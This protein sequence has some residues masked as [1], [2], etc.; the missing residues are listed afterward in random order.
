MMSEMGTFRVNIEIENVFRPGT[1]IPVSGVLVDTGAELS[2]FP[3]TVLESIGVQRHERRRFRL[4]SGEV[5]E[6]WVG[7]VFVHVM[8]KRATDDVVFGEPGDQTLLGARSIEGLNFR[9]D[10]MAKVLV[11][12]GPADAAFA[13]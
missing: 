5:I 8:G 13:A 9:V 12:A 1:R 6:R 10:P 11:D 2:W 4:A 7:P 3:A